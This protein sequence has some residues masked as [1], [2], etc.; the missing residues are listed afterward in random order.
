[1]MFPGKKR[2]EETAGFLIL[3][4]A[5]FF[6]IFSILQ[7]PLVIVI[8]MKL[9]P[10]I[11]GML[12]GLAAYA[13]FI[14]LSILD[15]VIALFTTQIYHLILFGVYQYRKSFRRTA[16]ILTV[17]TG[18]TAVTLAVIFAGP[19]VVYFF[20]YEHQLRDAILH[21]DPESV[22]KLIPL[23][24]K[25]KSVSIYFSS[26]DWQLDQEI[27]D[28]ILK[29]LPDLQSVEISGDGKCSLESLRHQRSLENLS[30][31]LDHLT[32]LTEVGALSTLKELDIQYCDEITTLEPLAGLSRLR[33]F[34]LVRCDRISSLKGIQTMTALE[35]LELR[36]LSGVTSM[37]G[38]SKLAKLTSLTLHLENLG[39][40]SGLRGL[41]SI[42]EL[43]IMPVNRSLDLSV[44]GS[45][46]PLNK[47][48]L[49]YSEIADIRPLS[50]LNGLEEL[51]LYSFKK[52]TDLRPLG[53]LIRLKKL[54][55]IEC[56]DLRNIRP[57]IGCRSLNHLSLAYQEEVEGFE[58]ISELPELISMA[59]Y[60]ESRKELI[61]R[62]KPG[63]ILE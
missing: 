40:I 44:I 20:D 30:I 31:R 13:M 54:Y 41:P 27:M 29:E 37:P 4:L 2:Y 48:K 56:N 55:L 21:D 51:S 15:P 6:V 28:L 38:L 47:L 32:G 61:L 52:L 11:G 33:R 22:R 62:L 9:T 34:S 19:K 17:T 53:M 36:D 59:G 45:L 42:Q 57:L 8:G 10:P 5:V 60:P 35:T 12:N 3:R 24:R 14:F 49:S 58:I 18:I 50:S 43:V 25:L 16:I 26:T 7:Y 39:D 46:T 63:I 1:M 23:N